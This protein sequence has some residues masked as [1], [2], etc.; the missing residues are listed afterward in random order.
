MSTAEHEYRGPAHRWIQE[1]YCPNLHCQK[2]YRQE[3]IF[4][5]ASEKA[6]DRF[7]DEEAALY[8]H[9]QEYHAD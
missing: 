9:N 5:T 1:F 3:F 6:L 2:M 8:I 7:H 4:G